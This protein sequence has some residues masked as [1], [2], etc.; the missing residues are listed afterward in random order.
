MADLTLIPARFAAAN[1]VLDETVAHQVLDTAPV[2]QP[3]L[4]R[5]DALVK[6]PSP[7]RAAKWRAKC[8]QMLG[9]WE[10]A[11]GEPL[12]NESLHTAVQTTVHASMHA[13]M[14]RQAA[15]GRQIV[16]LCDT[17]EVAAFRISRQLGFA[18]DTAALPAWGAELAELHPQG[19]I[20]AGCD[21]ADLPYWTYAQSAVGVELS[22]QTAKALAA[23]GKAMLL[24]I[25]PK[26]TCAI[27]ARLMDLLK[28]IR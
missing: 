19:F 28:R 22:T 18:C 23:Q 2:R 16:V 26:P 3:L 10:P 13:T 12:A 11:S 17:D 5:F 8:M 20:F 25:T 14:A 27:E 15:R 6:A 7:T 4:V 1:D 24:L 21:D 9:L